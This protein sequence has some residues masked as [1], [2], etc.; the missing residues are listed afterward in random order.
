MGLWIFDETINTI[1]RIF[2]RIHISSVCLLG[3]Y[4]FTFVNVIYRKSCEIMCFAIFTGMS[5]SYRHNIPFENSF[6][7]LFGT[8]CSADF[9][10]CT[11][12]NYFV[13]YITKT[14]TK[15]E[16]VKRI[17]FIFLVC[18]I[19]IHHIIIYFRHN[20]KHVVK[21]KVKRAFCLKIRLCNKVLLKNADIL[22][23]LLQCMY[24]C[25]AYTSMIE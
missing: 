24:T 23:I 19:K 20:K 9:L 6:L 5:S 13:I 18:N 12:V 25:I 3:M 16:N 22:C 15:R 14:T 10:R 17:Y 11:L 7:L 21:N 2:N 1:L 4:L 8:E